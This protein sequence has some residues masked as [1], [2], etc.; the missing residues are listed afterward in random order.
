MSES[1][2][3]KLDGWKAIADYLGKDTSTA[4]RWARKRGMPVHRPPGGKGATVY[5]YPSELDDWL[6]HSSN[7]NLLPNANAAASQHQAFER[8]RLPLPRRYAVLFPLILVLACIAV[9]VLASRRT[10]LADNVNFHGTK[11]IGLD[12][13]GQVVWEHDFATRVQKA[14]MESAQKA[15]LVDLG[16]DGRRELL[17][18]VAFTD[19]ALGD[20]GRE[21]LYCFS[22]AGQV[23][24][25]YAPN[26]TL[27]FGGRE[28]EGPWRILDIL[29]PP[30]DKRNRVWLSFAHH[31]WWPSFLVKLEPTGQS[32]MKFIDSGAMYDLTYVR[33]DK[34][35]YV[36]AGGVNN[37]YSAG[38]LA[39]IDE[40][41]PPAT[42]PQSPGSAYMCNDCPRGNAH[43]YF[44]FPRS[45]LNLL[46]GLPYNPVRY[47]RASE[48]QIEIWSDEVNP[49]GSPLLF[50]MTTDFDLTSVAMSDGYAEVHRR[51]SQQGRI[52]H[53]LPECPALSQP[54]TVRVWDAEHGWSEILVPWAPGSKE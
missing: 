21:K 28:Y 18:V 2:G 17:V 38:M 19:E 23:L 1:E 40:S 35:S 46:E 7:S 9:F 10:N 8:W 6:K 47:V 52:R 51:L 50:R 13:Q 27:S 41:Q 29:I 16:G 39:V 43:L 4:T 54:F 22:P 30:D 15:R 12:E 33:N 37:E 24:W 44:L 45:E 26:V 32:S 42:S 20:I 5:A 11:L 49:G 14:S 36:L 3:K 53:S 48:T 31:M 25:S 34:G